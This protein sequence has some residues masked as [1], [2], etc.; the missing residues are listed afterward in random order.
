MHFALLKHKQTYIRIHIC[1][2]TTHVVSHRIS[3]TDVRMYRMNHIVFLSLFNNIIRII[4]SQMHVTMDSRCKNTPIFSRK[5][6]LWLWSIL[7]NQLFHHCA[8]R[9][10]RCT[11]TQ[12]TTGSAFFH[13]Q[14]EYIEI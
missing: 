6:W 8:Y 2:F 3:G 13:S 1:A 14:V 9:Y 10:L 7:V 11:C 5:F 4:L 12:E